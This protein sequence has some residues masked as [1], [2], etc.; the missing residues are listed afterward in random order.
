M[1]QHRH[2]GD[3]PAVARIDEDRERRDTRL[4]P[5]APLP[6]RDHRRQQRKPLFGQRIGDL[7][8]IVGHPLAREDAVIDQ[9]REPVGE[10]VARDPELGLELLEM[11]Q[12]VERRAQDQERPALA[13]RL[14]RRGQA[15]FP[16]RLAQSPH[17]RLP[18][19]PPPRSRPRMAPRWSRRPPT[20][21][22]SATRRNARLP[23]SPPPAATKPCNL[24]ARSH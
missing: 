3:R 4:P 14:E 23:P 21:P 18:P 8:A 1:R 6:Q 19:I 17:D 11:V 22:H 24:A 20:V 10:D 9:P 12:P 2:R 5:L 16:Q 7:A 13:H 15:A